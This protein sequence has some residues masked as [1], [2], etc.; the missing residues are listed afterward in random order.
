MLHAWELSAVRLRQ[1]GPR[2]GPRAPLTDGLLFSECCAVTATRA[3]G[4]VISLS[5]SHRYHY[6]MEAARMKAELDGEAGAGCPG[7]DP[8][9]LPLGSALA[10]SMSGLRQDAGCAGKADYECDVLA[11][12]R[13]AAAI[14]QTAIGRHSQVARQAWHMYKWADRHALVQL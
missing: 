2:Q 13:H 10:R 4:P 7:G 3:G 9:A 11:Q 14:Y 8:G 1:P 6:D 5:V 12:A